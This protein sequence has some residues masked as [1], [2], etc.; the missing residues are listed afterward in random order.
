LLQRN[1]LLASTLCDLRDPFCLLLS[2]L[3]LRLLAPLTLQQLG[4]LAFLRRVYLCLQRFS[5]SH[6]RLIAIAVVPKEPAVFY[7]I[8]DWSWI[9]RFAAPNRWL[10]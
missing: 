3:C 6:V 5:R 2:L 1:E 8:G 4:G 10:V 9:R 7:N